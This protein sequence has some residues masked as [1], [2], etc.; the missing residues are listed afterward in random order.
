[1]NNIEQLAEKVSYYNNSKFL[2][3][4]IIEYDIKAANINMLKKY[5]AIDNNYYHYLSNL[6]K[7]DRE[8]I[9]GK[10]ISSD[11]HYHDIISSGI[12]EAKIKLFQS[13][14]LTE[15]DIVRIANDAVYT[16]NKELQYIKFD[17]IEFK[18]K[19]NFTSALKLNN[20]FILFNSN[21]ND[22]DIIGINDINISLHA[23]YILSI[24]AQ[25]IILLERGSIK[26]ALNFLSTFY[27]SYINLELDMNFYREL[28]ADSG[29]RYKNIPFLFSQTPDCKDLKEV[30]IGYNIYI[31]RELFSIILSY[32]RY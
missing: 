16:I 9:V 21:T 27:E 28:N 3:G 29:F 14:K 13:N 5:N 32:Y 8:V 19:S 17:L 24:I 2:Y 4:N 26:D 20:L 25:I 30:D 22:M 12:K 1:M 31:L 18:K 23:N 7:K 6:P 11:N 10:L 15:D